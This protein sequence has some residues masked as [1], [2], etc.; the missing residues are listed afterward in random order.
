MSNKDYEICPSDLF[1]SLK[2]SAVF[3]APPTHATHFLVEFL[4]LSMQRF[5]CL[6]SLFLFV[7][8]EG[9]VLVIKDCYCNTVPTL[10]LILGRRYG[11]FDA[12]L[13]FFL[14]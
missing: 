8:S 11:W 6:L 3:N 1:Q 10:F 2:V 7:V 9:T 14:H 12:R 5:S 13:S 4:Y